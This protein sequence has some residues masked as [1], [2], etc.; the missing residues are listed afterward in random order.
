MGGVSVGGHPF[1]EGHVPEGVH[2]PEG[3]GVVEAHRVDLV[4]L[5]PHVGGFG[6][7]AAGLGRHGIPIDGVL[8]DWRGV[9]SGLE[10]YRVCNKSNAK[11]QGHIT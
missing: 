2:H 6:H 4:E 11:M 8:N 9:S 10:K 7:L 5:D 1:G 3:V